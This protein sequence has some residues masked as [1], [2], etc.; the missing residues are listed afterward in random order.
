LLE[1][2]LEISVEY[3]FCNLGTDHTPII[4]ELTRWKEENRQASLW[5]SSLLRGNLPAILMA[6]KAP[7]TTFNELPR[8]KDHPI[9]FIRGPADQASIVRLY[10]NGNTRSS[11]GANTKKVLRRAHS[12]VES[13]PQGPVYLMLLRETLNEH[14]T[15]DSIVSFP[16]GRFAPLERGSA[17]SEDRRTASRSAVSI[18]ITANIADRGDLVAFASVAS[19][20]RIL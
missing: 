20:A 5:E 18:L 1:G 4:E 19:G 7:F 10:I 2:L 9:H 15:L 17:G 6:G 16:A 3:I 14:W 11:R 8:S 13:G 12:I